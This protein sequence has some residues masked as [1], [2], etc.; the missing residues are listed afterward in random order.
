MSILRLNNST[1]IIANSIQLIDGNALNNIFY[2]F[3]TK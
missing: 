2:D 1:D 3:K